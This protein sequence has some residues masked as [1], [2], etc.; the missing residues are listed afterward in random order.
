IQLRHLAHAVL[1]RCGGRT[2]DAAFFRLSE[3]HE[4][5]VLVE[6]RHSVSNHGISH[7]TSADRC[8]IHRHKPRKSKTIQVEDDM[9]ATS[10]TQQPSQQ[11]T[12]KNAIRPFH[13]VNVPETEL[14]ELRKRI[15]ATRWPERETVPDASQGVQLA[16]I[17]KLARYWAK[18]YDWRKCEATLNALA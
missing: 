6:P 18:D 8:R 14:A 3:E 12:D 9:T 10:A 17:Q 2:S 7:A 11:A 16:T 1:T 15:N 5:G 13:P 4:G